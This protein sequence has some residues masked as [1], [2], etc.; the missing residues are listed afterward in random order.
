MATGFT[1]FTIY[2]LRFTIYHL[3]PVHRPL[4]IINNAAAKARR[5]WPIARKRLE[6][7]GV[8]VDAYETTKPG[9]ATIQTRAALKAGVTTIAV[10]GGDGTLSE[11]AEGFFEF[12][13]NLD[14]LPSPVNSS[15]S[16]A[17]LPAGTGD[18]FARGLKGGNRATLEQWIDILIS[19]HRGQ[20]EKSTGLV[21][22]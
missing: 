10:V 1:V 19:H 22:V 20:D 16:L 15:A 12:R 9:D 2:H 3:H 5:A 11:A 14:E 18:D 6:V 8:D 7:G 17:I 21:D 13:E 4:I